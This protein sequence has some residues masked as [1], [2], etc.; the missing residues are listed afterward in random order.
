MDQTSIDSL[1]QVLDIYLSQLIRN[2][3][4]HLDVHNH[5]FLPE[6][7]AVLHACVL[8]MVKLLLR[9]PLPS[10]PISHLLP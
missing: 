7:P 8:K 10:A 9:L 1:I 5:F 2:K 4:G 3:K 6:V